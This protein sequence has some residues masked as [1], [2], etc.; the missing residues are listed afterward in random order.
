MSRVNLLLG[1]REVSRS[2]L[3][4][5]GLAAAVSKGTAR[6][7][8]KKYLWGSE[9][10][11]VLKRR[12]Q[13]RMEQLPKKLEEV[14]ERV[15]RF[16]AAEM[17]RVEAERLFLEDQKALLHEHEEL[18]RT[19]RFRPVSSYQVDLSVYSD[20]EI[21]A[22][23]A[24]NPDADE[25][26]IFRILSRM[27]RQASQSDV[28]EASVGE[29]SEVR[30]RRDV[31]KVV[32]QQDLRTAV[33]GSTDDR[34]QPEGVPQGVVSPAV[35]RT[36]VHI[37]AS[38]TI[39]SA[40]DNDGG[41]PF[42]DS[43]WSDFNPDE[44][45]EG[46]EYPEHLYE[47]VPDGVSYR[48]RRRIDLDELPKRVETPKLKELRDREEELDRRMDAVIEQHGRNDILWSQDVRDEVSQL[49]QDLSSI[50]RE[51]RAELTRQ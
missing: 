35:N 33:G 15:A 36:P 32:P 28:S 41:D 27:P 11:G 17:A 46:D 2:I 1:V 5:S 23:R 24:R 3:D 7:Q 45:I 22:V 12:V 50:S 19:K 20:A 9:R 37:E 34:V 10:P 25:E 47:A 16:R 31:P 38:V 30:P 6:K 40:T 14:E 39:S 43:D 26:A 18:V 4:L 44:W 13:I 42:S 21:A 29:V 8:G 51:L 49:R 48:L